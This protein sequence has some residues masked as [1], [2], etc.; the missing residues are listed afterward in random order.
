MLWGLRGE[1]ACGLGL[2]VEF[3]FHFSEGEAGDAEDFLAGEITAEHGDGATRQAEF[4]SEKFAERGGGAALDGRGVDLDLQGVTEPAAHYA[5]RG[6]GDGFDR[7]GAGGGGR[8]GRHGILNHGWA[9]LN[10]DGHG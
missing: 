8:C 4:V 6:V 9:R 1:A 5:A 7:E 3:G 10:T 2:H